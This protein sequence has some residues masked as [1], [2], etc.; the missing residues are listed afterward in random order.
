[1]DLLLQRGQTVATTTLTVLNDTLP[2]DDEHIYVYLTSLTSGVRVARPS[3][4]S[5]R[6]VTFFS[7]QSQISCTLCLIGYYLLQGSND[8]TV[9]CQVLYVHMSVCDAG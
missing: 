3:T 5:G 7:N 9:L 6:K 1:M 4:D 8:Y 2:E